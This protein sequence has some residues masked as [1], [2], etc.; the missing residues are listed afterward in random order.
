MDKARQVL[1][2][3]VPP[4]VRRSYR[5]LADHGGV[6]RSTLHRRDHGGPSDKDKADSQLYLKPWEESAL[7]KFILHMSDLSQPVRI[8]YIP[9]L[10]FVATRVRPPAD[11]PLKPPGKNWP[12]AFEKRHPEIAARR[13]TALDW[14]RHETNIAGKMTH[15]FEVIGRVLRD[16]AIRP[17]N[18]YNMDETG[19]MLSMLGSVKVLVGKDDKRKYRGARVKRT[20]VTA[21][22]CISAD[23]RYLN[24]LIIWPATTHQSNWTIYP[25]PGWQ[26]GCSES[27]YT[28][29][30]IS[31]E[32]LKR[33]FDPET[34]D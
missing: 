28:D 9:A 29:S 7:V 26:Y 6:P 24:P 13:V 1:G 2:R 14:N 18:F 22:E 3:G 11:R 12:K 15:W 32:W 21:I 4:G 16:P 5:T 8:K 10:A 34:R 23:G 17:E 19:V 20:T 25:T 31:L 30:H 33:I 27:G